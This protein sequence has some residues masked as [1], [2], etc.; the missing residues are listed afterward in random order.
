MSNADP[1]QRIVLKNPLLK[2]N[3]NKRQEELIDLP[4]SSPHSYQQQQQQRHATKHKWSWSGWRGVASIGAG[5]D[6]GAGENAP[7][8][9][10]NASTSP[11]DNNND[12]DRINRPNW[13]ALCMA[14]FLFL[15]ALAF[16]IALILVWRS[17]ELTPGPVGADG[18][19]GP[20]GP[21]GNVTS[22]NPFTI[23]NISMTDIGNQVLD[24]DGSFLLPMTLWHQEGTN[25]FVSLHL[26]VLTLAIKRYMAHF[27]HPIIPIFHLVLK[28]MVLAS[29]CLRPPSMV[30]VVVVP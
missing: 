14:F 17:S 28:L 3:G 9:G 6:G 30:V 5:N 24:V 16:A 23:G 8:N 20:P 7:L 22:T 10:G 12:D 18:P 26:V 15:G 29:Y 4:G 25:C 2:R 19:I 11:D 21:A 1:K 13:L 27:L